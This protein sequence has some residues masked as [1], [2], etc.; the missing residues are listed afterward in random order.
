MKGFDLL[1]L[2]DKSD[3]IVAPNHI[4]YFNIKSLSFLLHNCGFSV[5][6]VLTP[7]QMDVD[8]VRNKILKNDFKLEEFSFL[9]TMLFD[10]CGETVKNFQKF[11]V[12]NKLSS[13]MWIVARKM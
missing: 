7:G 13:H 11:L 6:E 4:N 3:N 9:K 2:G 12:E 1:V 5:L 10:E 8:I